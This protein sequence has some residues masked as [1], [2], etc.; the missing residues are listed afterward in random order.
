MSK[1]VDNRFNEILAKDGNV[2]FVDKLWVKS[3]SDD[4][5]GETL[6]LHRH[7]KN[8][9]D[10]KSKLFFRIDIKGLTNDKFIQ[11]LIDEADLSSAIASSDYS[12]FLDAFSKLKPGVVVFYRTHLISSE[13]LRLF[14]KLIKY[15]QH[16]NLEWKFVFYGTSKK[17]THIAKDR[18]FIEHYY[19]EEHKSTVQVSKRGVNDKE[20]SVGRAAEPFNFAKGLLVVFVLA[21]AGTFIYFSAGR[22]SNSIESPVTLVDATADVNLATKNG[23]DGVQ[24]NLESNKTLEEIIRESKLQALKFEETMAGINAAQAFEVNPN[25]DASKNKPIQTANT[26]D[27]KARLLPSDVEKAIADS[28]LAFL[29]SVNDKEILAYGRDSNGETPLIISVNN[30]NDQIVQWLLQQNVPV[31]TRDNY[32]RTA[33]SYSAIKG[34]DNFIK[35]LLQ[36]GARVSLGSNLSKTPLIAAVSNNHYGS[37]RLLLVTK[38]AQVNAQDHSGWS[39]LFYAIW[40]SNSRMVDLLLEFGADT[41]LVDT[42]G[43]TIDQVAKA[44]GFTDWNN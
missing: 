5:W 7:L 27:Q 35:L 36:A 31:D 14:S 26:Q 1:V 21:I 29:Q 34:N 42:S 2:F 4:G 25:R 6:E 41:D 44:A 3:L 16:H 40:N 18:L 20:P 17:L 13:M 23:L 33:L 15:V 30:E 24:D 22:P 12:I 11:Y 43:L 32:G 39:A 10:E 9:S 37:A 38:K 8:V 19:P 28:D